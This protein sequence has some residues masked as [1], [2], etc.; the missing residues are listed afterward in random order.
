MIH[1]SNSFHMNNIILGQ[2]AFILNKDNYLLA[3][4]RDKADIHQKMWDV[5]GGKVEENE[6]LFDAM[7][8]EIKEEVGLDLESI[9]LTLTSSKFQGLFGDVPPQIVRNIYLCRAKGDVKLS[10][11]H[12]EYKWVALE[13]LDEI[14]FPK[15]ED[16]MLALEQLKKLIGKID[17]DVNLSK[18]L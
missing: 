12:S 1:K 14:N 9:V 6:N 7:K 18:V 2:K 5:P 16:F 17:L 13:N 8:R 3:I 4:K 10:E 15:D 11:E